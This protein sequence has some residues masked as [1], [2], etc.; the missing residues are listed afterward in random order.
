M[1]ANAQSVSVVY[2]VYPELESTL[3]YPLFTTN[4]KVYPAFFTTA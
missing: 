3:V 2:P 1:K 4:N